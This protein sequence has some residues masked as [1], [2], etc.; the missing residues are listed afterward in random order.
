MPAVS[1]PSRSL[2]DPGRGSSSWSIRPPH[3]LVVVPDPADD[4]TPA[5]PVPG[6]DDVVA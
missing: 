3:E 6:E 4:A 5:L 2:S 1:R